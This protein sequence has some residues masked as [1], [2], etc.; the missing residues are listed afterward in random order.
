MARH[1][2]VSKSKPTN[3]WEEEDSRAMRADVL[4]RVAPSHSTGANP[5]PYYVPKLSSEHVNSTPLGSLP[6][7]VAL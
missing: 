7:G 2:A 6:L 3:Q 1:L 5:V 4:A